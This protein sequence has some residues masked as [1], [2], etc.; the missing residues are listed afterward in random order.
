MKRTLSRGAV[1]SVCYNDCST[2]G[3]TGVAMLSF[4]V[5]KDRR[6]CTSTL[7]CAESYG[8]CTTGAPQREG[9]EASTVPSGGLH[10]SSLPPS[11]ANWS[12]PGS[13]FSSP[14]GRSD[15]PRRQ[16][17]SSGNRKERIRLFLPIRKIRRST[18]TSTKGEGVSDW[19]S[20]ETI[21][22]GHPQ[23]GVVPVF[24]GVEGHRR[25]APRQE[26]RGRLH[27]RT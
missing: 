19:N 8:R 15:P 20:R 2:S 23:V 10:T 22:P 1:Q 12:S 17:F 27:G 6:C 16:V 3:R 25:R 24:R 11:P 9:W 21:L 13:A 5:W 4:H 18:A 7:A 14:L 26:C